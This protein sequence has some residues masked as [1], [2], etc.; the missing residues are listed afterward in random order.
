V[1][2]TF[3]SEIS[4]QSSHSLTSPEP[5]AIHAERHK[6]LLNFSAQTRL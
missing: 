5:R 3:N 1:L 4:F 2:K 6:N